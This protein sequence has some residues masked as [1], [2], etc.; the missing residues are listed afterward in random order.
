MTVTVI[1]VKNGEPIGRF[2]GEV[3]LN[4]KPFPAQVNGSSGASKGDSKP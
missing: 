3:V 1:Q 4:G 2:Q